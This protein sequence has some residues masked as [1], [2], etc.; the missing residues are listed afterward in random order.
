MKL[1][2]NPLIRK[3]IDLDLPE[4]DFAVFGSGPLLAHG[5]KDSVPDLDILARGEAWRKA[6]QISTPRRSASGVGD[7]VEIDGAIEIFNDW[8]P[9]DLNTDRLIDGADV[10]DGIRF[11]RLDDVLA[12][13]KRTGR[14]KDDEDIALLEQYLGRPPGGHGLVV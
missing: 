11:V 8:P 2:E 12:W 9:G 7:V 10:I 14:S 6:K 1:S 4:D 5:L 13:K 3:L